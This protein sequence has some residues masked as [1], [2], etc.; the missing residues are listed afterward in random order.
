MGD[1][2]DVVPV[3]WT[4]LRGATEKRRHTYGNGLGR[5]KTFFPG[6]VADGV[7]RTWL[8]DPSVAMVCLVADEMSRREADLEEIGTPI[9]WKSAVERL[10]VADTCERLATRLEPILTERVLPYRYDCGLRFRT[11][12]LPVPD[13]DYR[14]TMVGE[15]DLVVYRDSEFQVF[16][17]KATTNESYW[18]ST[19]GQLVFYAISLSM[20]Q[21]LTP[22]GAAIIQ[23]LC[24]NRW[25][26]VDIGEAA[27]RDLLSTLFRYVARSSERE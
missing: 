19:A 14:F 16:D 11:D 4:A 25:V 7:M 2:F 26:S 5:I 23:P 22:V 10:K 21:G 9:K 13:T 20:S 24:A 1:E 27:Q 15:A 8:R 12:V 17:L 3:S 18:R 6:N